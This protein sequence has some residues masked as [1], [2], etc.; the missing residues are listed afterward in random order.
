MTLLKVQYVLVLIGTDVEKDKVEC[1]TVR[2]TDKDTKSR[3][4]NKMEEE[5]KY[6]VRMG[7]DMPVKKWIVQL[8]D[9]EIIDLK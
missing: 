4:C 7:G 2:E 3:N 1:W 9:K 5:W 6:A 8:F